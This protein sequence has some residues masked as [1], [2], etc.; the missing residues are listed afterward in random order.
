MVFGIVGAS[1]SIYV[2]L[3]IILMRGVKRGDEEAAPLQE[4]P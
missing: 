1:S 4:R 2:A 3:P